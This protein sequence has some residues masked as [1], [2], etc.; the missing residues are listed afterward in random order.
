MSSRW[1]PSCDDGPGPE[2]GTR[3]GDTLYIRR[4]LVLFG[5][6]DSSLDA[7]PFWSEAADPT[8]GTEV[9]GGHSGRPGRG[10]GGGLRSQIHAAL[11]VFGR[12]GRG[13]IHAAAPA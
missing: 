7:L 4:G 12:G 3:P 1:G 11:V 13:K 10:H 2:P 5:R 8:P 6:R 9:D